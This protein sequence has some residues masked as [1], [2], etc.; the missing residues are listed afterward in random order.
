MRPSKHALVRLAAAE[1]GFVQVIVDAEAER[2][3]GHSTKR[4]G[5]IL[6]S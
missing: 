6:N 5:G 4:Q 2:R 3:K 1:L